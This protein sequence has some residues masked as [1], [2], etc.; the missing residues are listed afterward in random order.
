MEKKKSKL[1]AR[2]L[3]LNPERKTAKTESAS[4]VARSL[5]SETWRNYLDDVKLVAVTLNKKGVRKIKEKRKTSG[6]KK[7]RGKIKLVL[8]NDLTSNQ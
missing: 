8:K 5:F 6:Q 7:S 2:I 3:K 4:E 1:R